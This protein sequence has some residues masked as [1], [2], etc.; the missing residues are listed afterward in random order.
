VRLLAPLVAILLAA[1][2]LPGCAMVGGAEARPPA[3]PLV[4]ASGGTQGVYYAYAQALAQ[5]L[6]SRDHHLQVRVVP[7]PGSIENVAMVAANR[8]TCAFTADDAAAVAAAGTAPFSTPLPIAAVA[9]VYDD[10]IQLVVRRSSPVRDLAGLRGKTVSVGPHG[11]GTALI[12][13]R[14]L[15][16]AGMSRRD[17]RPVELGIDESVGA[18]Q[19]GRIDAFFWS[20]GV[21][22]AGVDHLAAR[23]PLRLIALADSSRA[24]RARY[25]PVYHAA[26]VPVGTYDLSAPVPTVAV[27]NFVVC[28]RD[29]DSAVVRLLVATIFD[30]QRAI[31][32]RV[33]AAGALDRRAAIET[34]P[35]PLHPAALRW[36]R[37]TKI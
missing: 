21:P 36:F 6:S 13:D 22:T 5:Q 10:Y 2:V 32:T 1:T 31:S 25:G 3:G 7:T 24:L 29:T 18:L 11:S 16:A 33:P 30:A 37:D 15:A 34:G 20:G 4:L 8:N 35:V 12:T 23:V 19:A 9:R 27:P 26:A 28:R 14:I 17:V